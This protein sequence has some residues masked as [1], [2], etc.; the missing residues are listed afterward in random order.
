MTAFYINT[1]IETEERFDITKFMNYSDNYDVL[2]SD[3][4]EN[5]TKLPLGGKYAVSG[6]E[7]RPDLLSYK[8][9][10]DTQYWWCLMIYNGIPN[11]NLIT[12]GMTILFPTI[13]TLENFYFNLKVKEN[14]R[15]R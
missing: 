6:E 3:F 7:K 8:I 11:A 1:D 10:N 2:T 15:N 14:A 9:Y 4:L 13:D 5:I 12:N